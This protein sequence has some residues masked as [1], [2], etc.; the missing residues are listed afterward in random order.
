MALSDPY[1]FFSR[2]RRPAK[3]KPAKRKP[4]AKGKAVRK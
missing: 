1:S 2:E 3:S 4:A